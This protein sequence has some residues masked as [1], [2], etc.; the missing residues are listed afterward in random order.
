MASPGL[1][2]DSNAGPTD[3]EA[4]L[5]PEVSRI[6][7]DG[8]FSQ[9]PLARGPPRGVPTAIYTPPHMIIGKGSGG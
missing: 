9:V 1:G 5:G 6:H 3:A 8:R 2:L 4:R 7:C